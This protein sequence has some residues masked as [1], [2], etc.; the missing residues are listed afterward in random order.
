MFEFGERCENIVERKLAEFFNWAL[1]PFAGKKTLHDL[2]REPVAQMFSW[3]SA[4]N[5]IVRNV[6]DYDSACAEDGAM[7]DSDASFDN[8][9]APDPHIIANS[10]RA[11]YSLLATLGKVFEVWKVLSNIVLKWA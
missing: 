5:R 9:S 1:P 4:D 7:A 8:D 3:D 10:G 6:S 11:R 2:R